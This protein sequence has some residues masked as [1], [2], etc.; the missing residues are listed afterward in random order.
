MDSQNNKMEGMKQVAQE[1]YNKDRMTTL[2]EYE[3]KTGT[4][5]RRKGSA[6]KK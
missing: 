2:K 1:D 6:G 3:V 5:Q 4:K